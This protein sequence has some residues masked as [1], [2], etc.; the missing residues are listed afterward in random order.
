MK[1]TPDQ[2]LSFFTIIII[3]FYNLLKIENGYHVVGGGDG[4]SNTSTDRCILLFC[5]TRLGDCILKFLQIPEF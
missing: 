1:K 4:N 2:K 3:F 5:M